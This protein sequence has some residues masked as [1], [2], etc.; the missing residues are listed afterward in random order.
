MK[1]IR[2]LDFLKSVGSEAIV[3]GNEDDPCEIL[4][5]T[6]LTDISEDDGFSTSCVLVRVSAYYFHATTHHTFEYPHERS[7]VRCDVARTFA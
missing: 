3:M 5:Y 7:T 4:A 1:G 6:S 2:C